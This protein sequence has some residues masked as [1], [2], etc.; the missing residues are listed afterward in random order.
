MK[1]FQIANEDLQCIADAWNLGPIEQVIWAGRGMN[2]PTLIVND[3]F[4]IRFD[5]LGFESRSR[6]FGEKLAYEALHERAIPAPEVIALDVSKSLVPQDFL[7]LTKIEGR[8]LIDDWQTLS[9]AERE[10]AG[11]EAGRYLALMH[12]INFEG[13]GKLSLLDHE[14]F[15][16]WYAYMMDVLDRYGREA[17]AQN[18][19]TSKE[20]DRMITVF[21]HHKSMLENVVP[22]RLVHWDYHFE[23]ILQQGGRITGI[24]DFEW[25]LSGD[26]NYDFKL[27]DQWESDCPG[28]RDLIYRG[29]TAQRPLPDDHELRVTLYSIMMNLDY[30]VDGA[31]D[32]HQVEALIGFQK[33]LKAVE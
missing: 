31:I 19:L 11:R 14:R 12:E 23:N 17:V 8:P 6:F 7:I 4:V 1:S 32:A 15:P 25:S 22:G 10:Q 26:P 13:Y 21:E 28:S 24:I 2:N 30:L 9:L 20:N 18:L 5:G 3:H 33:A 16:D 29:Y 27:R